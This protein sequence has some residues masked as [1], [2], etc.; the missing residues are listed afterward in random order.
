M[1]INLDGI[2]LPITTTFTSGED[3]DA[4]ALTANLL[5]WNDSGVVGYVVLGSTGE[6]VNLSERECLQVIETARRAVPERLGFIVGA[7]QQSTRGTIEEIQ[8]V[9]NAGADATL[10]ITPHYYRA[11]ITQD[12]LV[13]HYTAVADASAI[14]IILYSMPDLTGV[15]IEPETAARLSRH[16]NIIGIK[17][18][19]ADIAK[20]A[21]TVRLVRNDFAVMIG[22]GTVLC[23]A[24][25]AGALGGILAVG[26]VA[27]KLCVEIYEAV[28]AGDTNRAA[29]LQQ[30]LTPLARAVTKTYGIGGLKTAIEMAGFA[31]GVARAPLQRPS[32]TAIREIAQML[33]QANDTLRALSQSVSA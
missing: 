30:A 15:A 8:R 33:K 29:L 21:E 19:S 32:E 26:C 11:A 6:R 25:Q 2:L 23:E 24:L 22:N 4:E 5:K 3:F 18:S 20:L 1:P 9:A 16:A 17:D 28:R 12:V 14:P 10:V 7:G 13:S 31:G 27:P